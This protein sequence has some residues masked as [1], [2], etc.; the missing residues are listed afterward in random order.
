[1]KEGDCVAIE[2][3]LVEL[4][5][6]VDSWNRWRESNL[7]ILPDL[8]EAKLDKIDLSEINLSR[9]NLTRTNFAGAHLFKADLSQTNSFNSNFNSATLFGANLTEADFTK[10]DFGRAVLVQAKLLKTNLFGVNLRRAYLT[11]AYLPMSYLSDAD[12]SYAQLSQAVLDGTN[13]RRSNL[14]GANLKSAKLVGVILNDAILNEAILWGADL[15]GALLRGTYLVG[16][17]CTKANLSGAN[18]SVCQ[19]LSTNFTEAVFSGSCLQDWNINVSTQLDNAICDFI[20]CKAE[21]SEQSQRFHFH[22]RRPLYGTYIPGEFTTL[23]RKAL[24]TVD[25]IFADGIDWKAFFQSFQELRSRYGDENIAIQAIEKKSGGAFVIRLEVA[26]QLDKAAI[27]SQAKEL[28]E[29][30]LKLL[31]ERV[32]EYKD[33][34]RFLRQSNTNL[35][36][37]VETM[38]DKETSKV[39]QHFNAPV[40]AVA[41]NVE[42]NQVIYSLEQRQTLV[43]A[44]AEIQ[45]LLDQ[46]SKTYP[47]NTT[48]GKMQLAAEAIAQIE[49]NPTLMQ[50]VLSAI[51]AGGTAALEQFLN[52]PAASF[53]MGAMEDWKQ[54]KEN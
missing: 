3:H 21:W 43:E 39:T 46:L 11:H 22:D 51:Q 54:T 38:A 32:A 26:P 13:L 6:G 12:L 19:A 42:G 18:L 23:Y 17:D 28:Y 33:E 50:R 41:G 15:S 1:M 2:E 24:E 49:N 31:G 27:E 48:T 35:E 53:V 45:K 20:F 34:V 5:R 52:H 9:A 16:S 8:S 7:D 40:T 4:R 29:K 47:T 44:A 14:R 36:R 30:D 25:L 37:I 10:A